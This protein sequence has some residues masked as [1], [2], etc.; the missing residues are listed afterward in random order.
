MSFFTCPPQSRGGE[1]P[2]LV[3]GGKESSI[4]S[5]LLRIVQM[6]CWKLRIIL[7]LIRYGFHSSIFLHV[8][9]RASVKM[10]TAELYPQY[11]LIISRENC[12][13]IIGK[14]LTK[15]YS[16]VSSNSTWKYQSV[17]TSPGW[18]IWICNHLSCMVKYL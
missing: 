3:W 1:T 9:K 6:T 8:V 10:H 2:I 14:R 4:G 18:T 15:K 11:H 7:L 12:T 5:S 16:Q 13:F 17:K